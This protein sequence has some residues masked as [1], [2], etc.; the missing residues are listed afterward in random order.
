[1]EREREKEKLNQNRVQKR[2]TIPIMEDRDY[3]LIIDL[4]RNQ[5]KW[6]MAIN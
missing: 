2:A 4:K 1:M 5:M 3:Y 6:R